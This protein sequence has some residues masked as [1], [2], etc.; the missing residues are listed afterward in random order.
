MRLLVIT[1]CLA[2][3]A[4]AF[5]QAPGQTPPVGERPVTGPNAGPGQPNV[6]AKRRE[7]IKQRIRALRAYTLTEELGLDEATAGKLFPSLAR[8]DDEF[9]RLLQ[10][11]SEL[12]RRLDGATELK[13][14]RAIDKLIDAAIANQRKF[15]DTEDKRLAELRKIL[16]PAQTARLLIVL[17]ALERKIQNQ[18]QRAINKGMGRPNKRKQRPIADDDDDDDFEGAEKPAPQGPPA[19]PQ[20]KQPCDPFSSKRGC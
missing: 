2:I 16:A 6:A 12:Q 14:N 1:L 5:A 11:R 7:R 18:L 15:W 3:A 13:D 4:P 9:D 8:Y 20:K 17:P 19:G 10:E